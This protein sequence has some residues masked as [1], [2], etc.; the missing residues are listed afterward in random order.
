MFHDVEGGLF[1]LSRKRVMIWNLPL[2]SIEGAFEL[3][4]LFFS[5]VA[6]IASYFLAIRF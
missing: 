4:C 1:C 5:I 6:A 3:L 2:D